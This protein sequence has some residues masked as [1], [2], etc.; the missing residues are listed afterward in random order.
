MLSFCQLPYL[1]KAEQAGPVV[2]YTIETYCSAAYCITIGFNS[3][4]VHKQLAPPLHCREGGRDG[5]SLR[6]ISSGCC[7]DKHDL[8]VRGGGQ[9]QYE[10][11]ERGLYTYH[12]GALLVILK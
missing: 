7:T 1:T 4:A 10:G 3:V 5:M 6:C 9:Q 8:C 11:A 2:L 12:Q